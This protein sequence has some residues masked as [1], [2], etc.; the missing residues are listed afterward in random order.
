VS[1]LTQKLICNSYSLGIFP[2]LKKKKPKMAHLS[3]SSSSSAARRQSD[4]QRDFS[5]PCTEL[6]KVLGKS[7]HTHTHTLHIRLFI[8]NPWQSRPN[9][10][11]TLFWFLEYLWNVFF[12][13]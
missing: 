6:L 12:L 11:Q 1:S 3:T 5:A 4:I 13:M 9:S 2:D 7:Q 10:E 8:N